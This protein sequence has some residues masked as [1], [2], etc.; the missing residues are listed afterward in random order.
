MN[1]LQDEPF[2]RLAGGLLGLLI[3]ATVIGQVLKR[4]AGNA[5]FQTTIG[6]LNARIRSWWII[7]VLLGLALAT[8]RIG[9]VILFGLISFMALREFITLTPT[10]R[11][12]HRSLF[13]VFFIIT[14]V[15]Y[16][17]VARKDLGFF[18][19]LIPVY[20]FLL[21]PIRNVIAGDTER[22][23]ERTA[24]IQWGLMVCVYCVSHAPFLLNLPIRGGESQPAKL[25]LFFVLIVQLDD[26]LQDGWGKLLGQ[27]R[28]APAISPDQTWEGLVGGV[29][30]ATVI[31]AGLWWATPF[32]PLQA[33]GMAFVIA[34]M[35]A[36]G[37]LT[38]AAIKRDRGVKD[39]G[40]IF[41]GHGGMLDRIDSI[42]FAAPVFFHLTRYF[43][44]ALPTGS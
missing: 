1:L 22:F 14:P 30:S 41:G 24:K 43:F 28:I 20:A 25:L 44:T 10:R 37:K 16:V 9:T 19:V 35:G 38:M 31:G 33:A 26:V 3:T 29:S 4:R 18:S 15:Q 39:H 32:T 7:S 27:T 21:V 8:G 17:L 11:G 34:W 42:C 40:V 6:N 36:A 23:L 12:D 2:L 13:W 5:G